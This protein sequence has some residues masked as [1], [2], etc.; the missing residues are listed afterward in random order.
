MLHLNV[1][2]QGQRRVNIQ[3]FLKL[4][5]SS[6]K[7]RFMGCATSQPADS[8][9]AQAVSKVESKM[10]KITF[11]SNLPGLEIGDKSLPGVIVIQ[12]W[13]GVTPN[14]TE[15]AEQISAQGFRCLVPDLY[16]GKI[17]VDAEEASHLMNNLNFKEAVAELGQAA[18]YLRST[19]ASKVG[20]TGFCMG[21]ALTL[22]AMADGMNID[23]G[24]PFYGIPPAAYFNVSNIKKPVMFQY[25]DLD[26]MAGFSDAAAANTL[27]E[28]MKA[29]GNP[30][31]MYNY[32]TGGHGFM[33][34]ATTVGT[35]YLAK[36]GSPVPE[37]ADVKLAFERLIAFLKK[38]VA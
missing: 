25:G 1:T 10:Q 37:Q 16:K 20:C 13:W 12:E 27:A 7:P 24:A 34:A 18:D 35:E 30:I 32:P 31:E 36:A 33:N 21:G 38:N 15:L 2:S 6:T 26:K 19:G 22:A 5:Q 23:C 9:P 8:K 29:A 28:T 14:I 17:G 11:G 3:I 4:Q